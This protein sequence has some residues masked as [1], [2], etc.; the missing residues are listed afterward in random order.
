M[1]RP[2]L[3]EQRTK[4]EALRR[5]DGDIRRDAAGSYINVTTW[6]AWKYWLAALEANK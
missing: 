1:T 5:K 3:E 6:T 4:F 2:Q